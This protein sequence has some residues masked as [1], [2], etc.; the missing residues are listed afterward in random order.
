MNKRGKRLFTKNFFMLTASGLMVSFGYSMIAPLITPYGVFL[1]AGL[2]AAG[3]LTGIFSIAALLVRPLSGYLAD[4]FEKRNICILSTVLIMAA[5]AGYGLAV[6]AG[7]MF[8]VRVFHGIAFG[9]QGTVNIAVLYD[10]VPKERLAEGIGYYSLGQVVSQVCGPSLGIAIRDGCGYRPL[11][12]VV[13]GLSVLAILFLLCTDPKKEGEKKSPRQQE[14][15][16]KISLA[17]LVA[18]PCLVYALIGGLFSLENGV[19]N[20]FLLLFAEEKGISGIALFFSVNAAVLFAIRMTVGKIVDRYDI[21]AIVN[22]SLLTSAAAMALVGCGEALWV[23]LAAA[24][25]KAVGQGTGQISLQ[26]ACMKK[27]DAARVGIATSTFYIGA[28][29][30]Q[31]LG[32]IICG[33]I[34]AR[35]G[36]RVMFYCVAVLMLAAM[37]GFNYYQKK[38]GEVADSEKKGFGEKEERL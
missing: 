26:T 6:N 11:F 36:Y 38:T 33:E 16:R 8:A 21:T 34:S 17:R 35:M 27:V 10:Y 12:W 14:T 23:F 9:I 29:L 3:A 7:G 2:T 5:M 4:V 20:S 32:P 1:G 31:G 15:G 28:D 30:G 37:T 24:V 19:I 22:L 18:L 25:L 13:T